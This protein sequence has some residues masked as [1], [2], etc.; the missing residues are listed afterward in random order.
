MLRAVQCSG[1]LAFCSMF[2]TLVFIIS[3]NVACGSNLTAV[4]SSPL[5]KCFCFWFPVNLC[6]SKVKNTL[7]PLLLCL[8][9]FLMLTTDYS[10]FS[11]SPLVSYSMT[12]GAQQAL[13]RTMEIYSSTTRFALACNQSTKVI[14]PIQSRWDH[15]TTNMRAHTFKQT[16]IQTHKRTHTRNRAHTHTHVYTHTHAHTRIH[17]HACQ[18]AHTHVWEM[19]VSSLNTIVCMAYLLMMHISEDCLPWCVSPLIYMC[20]S[21]SQ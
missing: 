14:E 20:V 4:C 11:L 5:I 10:L 13:R 6:V 18:H 19:L 8:C 15:T 1:P 3:C 21:L 2:K 7:Q 9:L 12:S 16:H 17:A